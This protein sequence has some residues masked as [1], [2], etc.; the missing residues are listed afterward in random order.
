MTVSK[1]P[2]K[3]RFQL[4]GLINLLKLFF[5]TEQHLLKIKSINYPK[6][7][8]IFSMRHRHQCL[9]Y[10]VED[11][12][13]FYALIS[14]SNDGE[15]IAKAAEILKI[16]SIR[17][18]TN[19]RGVAA[20]L[21]LI[22]KLNEGNSAGIMIDGPRGPNGKVKDGIINISKLTGIPIIPVAWFSKDKTFFTFNTW[23]KLQVPIGPCST[24][25]LYG[26]PI[27]IP[28]DIEKEDM[29]NWCEKVENEM[30]KLQNELE[31]NYEKYLN[32]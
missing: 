20:S 22:E 11:K 4:W 12:S 26:N 10:G 31:T 25:A 8:F 24:I 30:N 19:R 16:K 32:L 1:R 2:F 6:E 5:L 17:G 9:V 21:E 3:E 7:Q 13:K 15:I 29:K 27:Y 18:S 14:A 28:S 23:D